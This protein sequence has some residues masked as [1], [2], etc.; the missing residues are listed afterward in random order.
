MRD[1]QT[2]DDSFD[3]VLAVAVQCDLVVQAVDL[4]IHAGAGETGLADLL[5]D[6][7]VCPFTGTYQ[8][9]EDQDA[10]PIGEVLDLVHDLL[11]RLFDDFPSAD[12]TVRDAGAGEQESKVVIDLGYG[13]YRRAGVVRGGLLVDGDGRGKPLDMIYIRLVHLPDELAGI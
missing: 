6:G 8:G 7:L 2:I 3:C 4:T 12:G 1:N 9:S 10:A 11:R 13:P 5:E